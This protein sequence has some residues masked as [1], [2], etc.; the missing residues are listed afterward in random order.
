MDKTYEGL[1]IPFN[2][3]SVQ[4]SVCHIS[5]NTFTVAIPGHVHGDGCYE[6]HYVVDG[7]G[8]LQMA[9]RS[10]TITPNTLYVTGPGVYHEQIPD[11]RSPMKEYCIY[12]QLETCSMKDYFLDKFLDKVQWFGQDTQNI[13]SIFQTIFDEL[14]KKKIG[15]EIAI[16]TLFQQLILRATRNY[17][18]ESEKDFTLS[19]VEKSDSMSLTVEKC[20]LFE[21]ATITLE[22]L[23]K[24]LGIS[25]RQTERFLKGK[26]GETF[27]QKKTH[28][29]M[30]AAVSFLMDSN[31]SIAEIAE[32]LGYSCGEHFS[33]AFRKYYEISPREYRR[34]LYQENFNP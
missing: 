10:Y 25:T 21:Y 14:E 29:R 30:S 5:L 19:R 7:Y 32:I 6:I 26:Y 1:R 34:K 15:Y 22:E 2:L 3:E 11:Q 13:E 31:R 9:D 16:K 12:I 20:F 24:R 4:F 28:A 8:I 27:Q 18:Y 33:H 23:A 17:E